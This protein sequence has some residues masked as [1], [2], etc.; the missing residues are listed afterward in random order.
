MSTSLEKILAIPPTN[1]WLLIADDKAFPTE[2]ELQDNRCRPLSDAQIWTVSKQTQ[3]GD[4]LFCYFMAPRKAIQFAARAASYPFFD[5]KIVVNAMKQVDPN[6]WWV[7]HTPLVEVT[8]VS[9][10]ALRELMDGFLN[11]RG[12]PSHYI[13]PA[14]VRGILKLAVDPDRITKADHLLFQVPV[15]SADL[16]DPLQVRLSGWKKMADGPLKA[17]RQVEQYV[18]DPLLRL[19]L[20][21]DP[22]VRWQKAYR[23]KVGIPDYVVLEAELPRSVIEVKLGVRVPRDG[24][25]SRSP[26]L[27]QVLRY[28]RELDVAAALIDCN[29][30]FLIA[31]GGSAPIATIER[32][33]ANADDLRA[34][35]QHLMGSAVRASIPPSPQ[36]GM[37][38]YMG[39]RG[40]RLCETSSSECSD[41]PGY[42]ADNVDASVR[43][44]AH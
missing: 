31:R 12:K 30:I 17:E 24:D 8:P 22:A 15:G 21:K 34:I 42:P 6:Q 35:G 5:S 4:L 40:H 10:A 32:D 26:D 13:P 14:V 41:P 7:K 2:H 27:K 23:L 3:P 33:R 36:P 11:L 18:V 1:A 25:W 28:S 9:F 29:K 19:S 16:P 37:L 20:P 43:R 39:P 44:P 38:R